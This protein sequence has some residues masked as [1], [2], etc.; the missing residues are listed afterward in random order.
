MQDSEVQRTLVSIVVPCF[1]E[2]EVIRATYRRLVETFAVDTCEDIEIVFVDDGSRD[3]TLSILRA[4]QAADSRVRVVAF[5]RNFGHQV[6]VTAGLEH[7]AGDAVAII[8]A[9]LQD[10]PEVIKAM[11][12]RWHTGVDVAYGI[13]TERQGETA[14][15]R[16]TAKLFY[17]S[18]NRMSDTPI[19]LDTG[20]FRL[21]DRKVVDALLNMPEKDRFV[22]G[23]VAWLGFRQEPVPYSR[24]ARHAGET[25]YPFRKML[26]FAMD[27]ILSF[28][29]VPLRVAGWIGFAITGGAIIGILYSIVFRVLTHT[30]VS[31]WTMLFICCLFI[32]GIQLVSL[33]VLGEYLGRVYGEV[34]RRPLYVVR[35]RL[36]FAATPRVNRIRERTVCA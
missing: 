6:A 36:G 31:G 1:N 25:K 32:G 34:K 27:G 3:R 9:D 4:L 26:R 28:S 11:L 33:G 7:A 15:K 24:A 20:D 5:S 29:Q 21:M 23:M 22:R 8:D 16:W 2:E 14:F 19:P 17:R 12:E 35:E 13:R 18:I 10:P 30:W